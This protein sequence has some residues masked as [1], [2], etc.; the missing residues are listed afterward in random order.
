MVRRVLPNRRPGLRC[1][2]SPTAFRSETRY[3]VV[4]EQARLGRWLATLTMN[5]GE[6]MTTCARLPGWKDE[7]VFVTARSAFG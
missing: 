4:G 7:A 6:L 1:G 2:L 3:F 5:L